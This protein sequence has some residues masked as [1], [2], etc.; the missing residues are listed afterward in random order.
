MDLSTSYLGLEL[1]HPLMPGASPLGDDLDTVKRLEDAGAAAIVLRSL[2][3]EQLTGEQLAT[4]HYVEHPAESFAEAPSYLPRPEEFVLGPDDYLEHIRKVVEAVDIPVIG[5]LNGSTPG[6]WLEYAGL[7][8]QA[9]AE[10]LELNVYQVVTD[11]NEDSTEVEGRILDVVREV[12]GSITIPLAVKLSPHFTALP[13]LASGLADAGARGV[14][15]FN[16]FY[17]ADIDPENLEAVPTLRLSSSNELPLRLTWLGILSGTVNL[18]LGVTGGVHTGR[19]AV[20]AIMAGAHGVQLV[21]ALLVHGPEYLAT[22]R[23]DMARWL[24]EH[25]YPSLAAMRGNM[26][27]LRCPDPEVYQRGNYMKVLQSWKGWS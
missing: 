9:G 11:P 10:A 8:A 25:E 3:E 5:S 19:D 16:R 6:G 7:I 24:H 27:L 26:N 20:K 23:Q 22:V 18:S 4:H 15:L 1:P 12:S 2:F 21:S 17:Q 13:R 14:L